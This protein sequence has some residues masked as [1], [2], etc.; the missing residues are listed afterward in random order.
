MKIFFVELPLAKFE[1]AALEGC[2]R[3]LGPLE[4]PLLSSGFAEKDD[5]PGIASL[6]GDDECVP[7]AAAALFRELEDDAFS[8]SVLEPLAML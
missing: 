2:L 5:V 1:V 8:P 3:F 4:G 7:F 6:F